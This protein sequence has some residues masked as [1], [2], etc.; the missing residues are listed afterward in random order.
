MLAHRVGEFYAKSKAR[1]LF[2]KFVHASASATVTLSE[3]QVTVRLGMRAHNGALLKAGY[4]DMTD[5][6]PWLQNRWLRIDFV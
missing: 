6:I 4:L 3:E 1:T 5:P 2:R